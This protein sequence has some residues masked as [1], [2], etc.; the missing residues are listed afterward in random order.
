MRNLN[1]RW[2]SC[3]VVLACAASAGAASAGPWPRDRGTVFLASEFAVDRFSIAARVAHR[4]YLEYG[5]AERFTVGA[6]L[7]QQTAWQLGEYWQVAQGLASAPVRG[8]VFVRWHPGEVIENTPYAL[9][10]QIAHNPERRGDRVRLAAHLGHGFAVAGRNAWARLEVSAG[11][12]GSLKEGQRD[13][14]IQVGVNVMESIRSWVN[15]GAT[16]ADGGRTGRV[17]LSAAIDVT[18][19]QAVTVGVSRTLDAFAE[20]G[21]Q[22]GLWSKF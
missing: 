11:V 15:L 5:I 1:Y 18:D 20:T 14:A 10:L 8:H 4:H 6:K 13:G 2:L 22:V 21:L 9:E 3:A 12:A 19:R 16:Y 17:T 7:E